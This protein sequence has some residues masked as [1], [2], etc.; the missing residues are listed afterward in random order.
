MDQLL[1]YHSKVFNVTQ[2]MWGISDTVDEDI[3]V[4]ITA[5]ICFGILMCIVSTVSLLCW[6]KCFRKIKVC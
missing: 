5:A 3:G 1:L 2:L 6:K 4:W